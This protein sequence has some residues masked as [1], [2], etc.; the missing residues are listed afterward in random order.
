MTTKILFFVPNSCP[1][2]PEMCKHTKFI[3]TDYF[4]R[5]HAEVDEIHSFVTITG[6]EVTEK[7]LEAISAKIYKGIELV[8]VEN[9][10][11]PQ[12][13]GHFITLTKEGK[14]LQ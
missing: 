6:C 5:K 4:G 13:H 12:I 10:E 3:I 1:S 8:C 11:S 2:Y 9:P 7:D 14:E